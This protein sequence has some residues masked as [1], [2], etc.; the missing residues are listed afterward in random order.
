MKN[1]HNA[2]GKLKYK[3]YASEHCLFRYSES[4]P[5][6]VKHAKER[7][8][9]LYRESIV[10]MVPRLLKPS[11]EETRNDKKEIPYSILLK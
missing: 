10:V 2:D 7:E 4:L 9:N 5:I 6:Q 11:K 3:F 1:V 8:M